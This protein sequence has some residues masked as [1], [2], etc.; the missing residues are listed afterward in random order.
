MA[1]HPIRP[2]TIAIAGVIVTAMCAVSPAHAAISLP[3]VDQ[4]SSYVLY[5]SIALLVAGVA[6]KMFTYRNGNHAEMAQPTHNESDIT[7][8]AYRNKMLTGN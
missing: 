6:A 7:I 2:S 1:T 8:G 4:W 3:P 5:G